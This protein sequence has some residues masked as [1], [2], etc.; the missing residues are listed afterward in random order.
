MGTPLVVTQTSRISFG[1]P[2]PTESVGHVVPPD[3]PL[4]LG[5]AV[6]DATVGRWRP[7]RDRLAT[8]TQQV[9]PEP[10]AR[11][12]ATAGRKLLSDQQRGRA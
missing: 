6:N 2:P 1:V 5:R 3:D 12:L 7:N 9:R 11:A 10:I 4:P 8:F